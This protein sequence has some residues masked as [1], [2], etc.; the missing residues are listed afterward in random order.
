MLH[1]P[2]LSLYLEPGHCPPAPSP[3]SPPCGQPGHEREPTAG[4][5]VI[6][7]RTQLGHPRAAA[8]GDLHPD[9]AGAGRH[10]DR[11]RLAGQSRVAVPHA[12]A[13]KLP[14]K[15]ASSPHGWHGPSTAPTNVR[16]TRTRSLRPATCTLSRTA[17]LISAPPSRPHGKLGGPRAGAREIHAHL[18]R[19][20][21]AKSEP[22]ARVPH[23]GGR[24]RP[25][26]AGENPG[27][28][29][30]KQN[31]DRKPR[32]DGASQITAGMFNVSFLLT[33]P[34]AYTA[35]SDTNRNGNGE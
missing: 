15:T 10:G 1:R 25:A 12:V 5:C 24:V 7:G 8:V 26:A 11:D 9:S 27:Q 19:H 14:S 16:T 33:M 6:S 20:R 3:P 17:R 31:P 35:A 21:Q 23:K 18:S 2:Q 22:R 34:A 32:P 13:E 28:P 29:G 30:R 4:F